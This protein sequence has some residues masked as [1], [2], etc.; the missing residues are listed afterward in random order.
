MDL[1]IAAMSRRQ[2]E[3]GGVER[4]RRRPEPELTLQAVVRA[5]GEDDE[6]RDTRSDGC[7][8]P[9]HP[10]RRDHGRNLRA[11]TQDGAGVRCRGR[12]RAIQRPAIDDDRLDLWRRV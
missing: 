2:F 10:F 3:L 5:A 7:F 12:Q 11:K 6:P 1:D 4:D 9:D 8:Q